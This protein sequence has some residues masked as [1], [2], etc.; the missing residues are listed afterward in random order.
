MGD[1]TL[2]FFV[3]KVVH[4]AIYLVLGLALAWAWYRGD[5]TIPVGVFILIGF[6]YGVFDEWHQSFVPGRQA[7]ATDAAVDAMGVIL[8]FAIFRR[9]G[10]SFRRGDELPQTKKC[11][12]D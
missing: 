2:P 6:G 10:L 1:L 7:S 9:R 4:G 3:D 12:V 11:T 8:G 5:A